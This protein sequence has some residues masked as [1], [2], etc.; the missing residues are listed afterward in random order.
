VLH[1]IRASYLEEVLSKARIY[2]KDGRWLLG[3]MDE[4]AVVEYGE[5]FVQVSLPLEEDTISGN[6]RHKKQVITG[7]VIMAKNPC[8]HPGDIRILQAV[9]RPELHHLV[10]CLV[11]PQKGERPHSNEA[12]GSD[13]DGDIYFVSWDPRL[14]PPGG[15]S[16]EPMPYAEH[17]ERSMRKQKPRI[18]VSSFSHYSRDMEH[19]PLSIRKKTDFLLWICRTSWSFL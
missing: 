10:D 15:K 12:S 8:L 6:S 5:C 7:K 16:W 1:C 3:C 13:L 19:M 2:V 17:E 9:D 14:I 11:M 4:L 18:E